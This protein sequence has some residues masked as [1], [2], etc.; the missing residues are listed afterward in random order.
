MSTVAWR[1]PAGAAARRSRRR[2]SP[3]KMA[4]RLAF[5]L[6]IAVFVVGMLFPFY[7]VIITSLKTQADIARGTTSLLPPAHLSFRA[8]RAVLLETSQTGINFSRAL[9]NSVIIGLSVTTATVVLTALGG[10]ALARTRIRGKKT[11]LGFALIAGFFPPLAMVGP[12]FL[13][14]S[15]IHLLN[16]YPSLIIT[17]MIYTLPLGTWFLANFFS[18]IPFE[19]EEAA[20]I[21]GATRLQTLRKIIFPLAVPGIYTIAIIAFILSWN[22]FVFAVSFIVSPS[23]YT[24][25]LAIV[26][27]SHSQY[28]VFYNRMD[29]AVVIITLPV[30]LLV[31]FAQRRIISGLTAGALK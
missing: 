11:V 20:L 23:M 19:L 14:Y 21:D 16:S 15:K 6:L 17:Y 28:Q 4:R 27:L 22:D 18:Q 2:R 29:A 24:A 3:G 26:N 30:A 5:L 8:Y 25:P 31:I 9:L 7:W 13:T 12:M 10:Y 1:A